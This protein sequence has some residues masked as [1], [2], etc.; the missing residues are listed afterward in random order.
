MLPRIADHISPFLV[1]SMILLLSRLTG[2]VCYNSPALSK[3]IS[4]LLRQR[5]H[6]HT[7]PALQPVSLGP[8]RV[9]SIHKASQ[10]ECCSPHRHP[11]DM[12]I[13]RISST[14]EVPLILF[15]SMEA[16]DLHKVGSALIFR[17]LHHM[18]LQY[19]GMILT[20]SLCSTPF[21]THVNTAKSGF[22]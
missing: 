14:S 4:H 21:S 3:T 11:L 7:L 13:L 17:Q 10:Q 20:A 9:C 16:I 8:T 5:Y 1:Y 18:P 2:T 22:G 12:E 6:L 15:Y 19:Q